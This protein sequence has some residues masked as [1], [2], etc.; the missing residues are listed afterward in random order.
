MIATAQMAD[1][2]D[3]EQHGFEA[4]TEQDFGARTLCGLLVS[5]FSAVK[6]AVKFGTL[7]APACPNCAAHVE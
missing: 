5:L 2:P 3:Q 7:A 6:P 1:Y 4:G